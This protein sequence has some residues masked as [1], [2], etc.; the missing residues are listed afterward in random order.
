MDV[1]ATQAKAVIAYARTLVPGKPVT[2]MIVSHHHFDHT[3]GLRQAVAEGLTIISRRAN[4]GIFQVMTAH[5]AA[6]FL[7]DLAKSKKT[8]KF[9]P[10]DE[11]L[12]LSDET[13]V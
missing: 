9:T 4:E 13:A 3:A 12:R 11:K 1:A 2:Q 8:L 7:D 10:V 6:D 5:P